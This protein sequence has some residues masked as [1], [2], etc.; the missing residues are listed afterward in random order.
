MKFIALLGS[1][2][3]P[4]SLIAVSGPHT[5][6]GKAYD[7]DAT[8]LYTC[9]NSRAQTIFNVSEFVFIE[10]AALFGVYIGITIP[11]VAVMLILCTTREELGSWFGEKIHRRAGGV[12]DENGEKGHS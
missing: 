10:G 2:F 8:Y 3:L 11:F 12:S 6:G 9:A 5:R 1:V 4:A 7:G